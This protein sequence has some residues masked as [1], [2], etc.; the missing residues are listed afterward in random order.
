LTPF[1]ATILPLLGIGFLAEKRAEYVFLAV[2]LTLAATS[3]CWGLRVHKQRRIV[4]IFVA[5]LTLILVG[6]AATEGIHEVVLV[7]LGAVLFVCG[8][9]LNYRL[10]QSC[11]HCRTEPA[12]F[13]SSGS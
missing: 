10:S 1:A 13:N 2:S 6:R 11:R 5:A 3:V 9:L 4:P 7:V 12:S 8:H